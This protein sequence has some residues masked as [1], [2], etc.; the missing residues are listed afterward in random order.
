MIR[1]FLSVFRMFILSDILRYSDRQMNIESHT[2]TDLLSPFIKTYL[3]IESQDE[4]I[5]R[6]LPDTSLALAFRYKGQ[7]NYIT[8]NFL[9]SLP[10]SV[11]SGLRT[12]VRLINYSKD[13]TTI[14]ILFK[15]AGAAAF[16]K[17]PLHELF[18]E[19]ISLDNFISHR[20][21]SIIEEQLA[22]AQ[23]N[24][25]RIAFVEQFLLSKLSNQ[26]PDKLIYAAIQKIYAAKGIVRIKELA[27]TLYI[28]HDAFE[29]RFRKTVGTSPKRFSSIVR[30]K[31][32][33]K[34][35]Q[36]SQTLTDIAFDAGYFD[37]P[38]FNKDF[39]LFTGQT[40]TDFFKSPLFW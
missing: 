39:K 13:T 22:E 14:I 18:E 31:S 6:V 26:G 40:P 8:G 36:Q 28:S 29:K 21:I 27:G 35:R 24:N 3:I 15:E 7:V 37:Q 2:P 12:S 30:M 34:Q 33:I 5:N 32:I 38:H 23:N 4:L 11:I 20:K 10:T 25:Q 19:S 9:N 16:F 17:E 1:I